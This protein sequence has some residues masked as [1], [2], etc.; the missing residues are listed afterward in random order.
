MPNL[1][2]TAETADALGVSISKVL[3]LA[4][5]GDLPHAAKTPGIRGAYLFDR[6]TVALWA[7]QNGRILKAAS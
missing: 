2:S 1:L 4:R 5:A 7:R 6:S 3:R